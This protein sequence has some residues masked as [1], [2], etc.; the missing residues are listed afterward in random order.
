LR[1]G[2]WARPW[3]KLTLLDAFNWSELEWR[4]DWHEQLAYN[5]HYQPE[6]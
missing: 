3:F 5:D 4:L 2:S 1:C 6:S